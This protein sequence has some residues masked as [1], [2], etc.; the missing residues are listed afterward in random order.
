M[1][2]PR[3]FIDLFRLFYPNVCAVCHTD[4][5][6]GE[7][8]ICTPC[9]Y[10][11]PRTKYWLDRENPVAQIFWGRVAIE[12]ACAFFFFHKGSK[13][14]KLLHLL[15]YRGRQE[16][17][18]VLGRE[19]GM[20]LR[21]SNRFNTL[22]VIVPVPLHPKRLRQRGYNQAECI[23]KGISEGLGLPLVTDCLVRA[24]YTETQT[25]KSRAERIINVSNA[26]ALHDG[27]KLTGKH[28]LLVDDVVTTGA[29]LEECANTLLTI[30]RG[31]VSIA[32]V[33]Y[34]AQ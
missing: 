11:L 29:T 28:I 23:A 31:R 13:Y 25:R 12:N 26:F 24:E 19:L 33:A 16:I 6:E 18:V 3:V 15:K 4:L 21:R 9:L 34:A 1:P 7:E 22:D 2:I 5:S 30:E 8:A 14:R 10:R 32:T 17:G 20:E 27:S